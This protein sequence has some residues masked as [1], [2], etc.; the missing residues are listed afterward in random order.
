MKTTK[1]QTKWEI[2]A[3]EIRPSRRMHAARAAGRIWKRGAK[4]EPSVDGDRGDVALHMRPP[5][6]GCPAVSTGVGSWH[7]LSALPPPVGCPLAVRTS[8]VAVIVLGVAIGVAVG[9]G[10]GVA[11]GVGLFGGDVGGAGASDSD[12]EAE[13]VVSGPT[14]DCKGADVGAAKWSFSA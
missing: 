11:I 12:D 1:W 13:A 6:A 9:V 7:C 2:S 10:V 5:S 8:M 14:G 3:S 4:T